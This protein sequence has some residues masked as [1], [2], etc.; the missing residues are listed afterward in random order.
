[1]PPLDGSRRAAAAAGA[2]VSAPTLVEAG[3]RMAL[4]PI[5]I[6]DGGFRGATLYENAAYVPPNAV[7]AMLKKRA[8]GKYNAKVAAKGKRRAH[9]AAN[10]PA[11]RAAFELA[12]VFR[13]E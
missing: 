9:E 3:P 8:A 13:G 10:P 5:R 1:V 2:D 11:A 7:R 6:F 12:E 4:Q